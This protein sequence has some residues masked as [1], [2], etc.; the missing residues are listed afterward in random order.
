MSNIIPRKIYMYLQDTWNDGEF[1]KNSLHILCEGVYNILRDFNNIPAYSKNS[2]IVFTKFLDD[3][4]IETVAI[5]A[6]WKDKDD[7][8]LGYNEMTYNLLGGVKK[9]D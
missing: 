3:R 8:K 4:E 2:N 9:N 7:D 1:N 5:T 6:M